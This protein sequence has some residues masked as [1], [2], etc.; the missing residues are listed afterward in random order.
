MPKYM[1]PWTVGMPAE[2]QLSLVALIVSERLT[3]CRVDFASALRTAVEFRILLGRLENAWHHHPVARGTANIR[4]VII[5]IASIPTRR[6]L[7]S[8]LCNSWLEQWER[9]SNARLGLPFP[10]GEE[11]AGLLS[12]KAIFRSTPRLSC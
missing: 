12:S 9:I 7:T 5:S 3:A 10:L 6:C 2:T 11:H 4:P 1:M 8:V